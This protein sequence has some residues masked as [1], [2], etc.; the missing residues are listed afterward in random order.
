MWEK[1]FFAKKSV[2]KRVGRRKNTI[3]WGLHVKK[4]LGG[5]LLFAAL[6]AALA[7]FGGIGSK[8]ASVSM[9]YAATAVLSLAAVVG[10]RFLIR[11]MEPWFVLLFC[12]VFVVNAGYLALSLSKT[13]QCALWANRLSYLGSVFL[14]LSMLMII[15]NTCRLKYG[16]YLP[17]VLLGLSAV[18]FLIAASPGILDVYY[19]EVSLSVVN[20]TTVLEKVYGP[21]HC[22]Y[23]FYLLGYFLATA[24]VLFHPCASRNVDSAIHAVVMSAA[25]FVNI[26]VW[27]LEQFVRID[28]ELLSVSYIVS[29][30]FLLLLCLLIQRDTEV[31]TEQ[32][33][34]PAQEET[35]LPAET[36]PEQPAAKAIEEQC[37]YFAS[38][39]CT[40]TPTER[41]IYDF[42]LEGK[43]TKEIMAALNIK[44]NTLKYHNKNIYG[45]LGVSSRKQLVSIAAAIQGSDV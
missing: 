30:L 11:K 45:K 13:L 33:P 36:Q 23:L 29:E 41:V 44:E 40:L 21:L 27:L 1:A 34:A 14:P 7:C 20:G 3:K 31:K 22:I 28:F 10:Y 19:K 38:Q 24:A 18:I 16:K 15:L 39:L 9:I 8:A 5:F 32:I 25:L 4:A 35:T 26:G 43:S 6:C 12:S 42:Y 17:K 37:A 2:G